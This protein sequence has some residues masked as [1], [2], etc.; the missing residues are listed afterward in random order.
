MRNQLNIWIMASR[1][2]TLWAAIA[3]VIIG[4]SMA[5]GAGKGHLLAAILAAVAAIFIQI[6]TNFAND[7]FDYKKGADT[8]ERLGPLRVTQAGLLS[9]RQVL[10]GMWATFGLAAFIGLYLI[11]VGGWP[12][13]IIGLL[14]IASGIVYHGIAAHIGFGCKKYPTRMTPATT[15]PSD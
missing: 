6:G 13:V 5:Y 14:S 3:P 2:K 11:A 1:P 8:T 10:V 12:I 15:S 7:V 4:T 9:P